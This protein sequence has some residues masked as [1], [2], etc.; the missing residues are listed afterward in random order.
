MADKARVVPTRLWDNDGNVLHEIEYE[1]PD[2]G[3]VPTAIE[4]GGKMYVR[5]QRREGRYVEVV[6]VKSSGKADP[7]DLAPAQAAEEE[8]QRAEERAARKAARD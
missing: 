1:M 7:A 2:D 3:S 4:H 5:D 8:R 6:A